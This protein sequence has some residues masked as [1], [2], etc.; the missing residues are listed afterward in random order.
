M[1]RKLFS[2]GRNYKHSLYHI[3]CS[4]IKFSYIYYLFGCVVIYNYYGLIRFI[5]IIFFALLIFLFLFYFFF[6][7]HYIFY[8][9]SEII[10]LV[11]E[12]SFPT[13]Q[14]CYM[15]QELIN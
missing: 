7:A 5:F 1:Q 9:L 14:T 3:I 6:F 15:L 2:F 10:N 11:M 8:C 13:L 12:N 4:L